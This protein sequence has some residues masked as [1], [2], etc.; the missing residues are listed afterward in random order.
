MHSVPVPIN[1]RCDS[2]SYIIVRRIEV[3]L[4]ANKRTHA[5]QRD[6]GK[7]RGRLARRSLRRPD[8]M[9]GSGGG[10]LGFFDLDMA[11]DSVKHSHL[12]L[13]NR[14]EL[15]GLFDG[16]GGG[17][18]QL[19]DIVRSTLDVQVVLSI[20]AA[21]FGSSTSAAILALNPFHLADA[22]SLADLTFWFTFWTAS[23]AVAC[24]CATREHF[25]VCFLLCRCRGILG[26]LSEPTNRR[27][28]RKVAS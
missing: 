9:F 19:L 15:R 7:K 8:R 5:P 12:G 2:N 28:V 10:A 27:A 25:V 11:S 14:C 3:T 17:F 23:S 20:M 1:V 26:L 21:S 18:V 16:V 22:V 4:R 13:L 24:A 6:P